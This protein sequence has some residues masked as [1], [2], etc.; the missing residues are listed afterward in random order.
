[1]KTLSTIFLVGAAIIGLYAARCWWEASKTIEDPFYGRGES[2]DIELNQAL[3]TDA[4][5][6]AINTSAALNK[7]AA[8]WTAASVAVGAIGNIFSAAN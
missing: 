5:T 8:F 6:R 4:N 2:G 3:V 7:K 1:M